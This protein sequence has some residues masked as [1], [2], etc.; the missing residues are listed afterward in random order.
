MYIHRFFFFHLSSVT[1]SIFCFF[2]KVTKSQSVFSSYLQK[3]KA[4]CIHAFFED[5]TK[6]KMSHEIHQPLQ[7]THYL[8]VQLRFFFCP[9]GSSTFLAS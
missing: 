6:M 8:D 7:F 4:Q 3:L 9:H 5:R 2:V 1:L